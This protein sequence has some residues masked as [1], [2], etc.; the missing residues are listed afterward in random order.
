MVV[1]DKVG[2]LPELKQCQGYY[3]YDFIVHQ[4][5]H[6]YCFSDLFYKGNIPL[7]INNIH[8][9][10]SLLAYKCAEKNNMLS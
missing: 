5:R 10:I 7:I 8:T 6:S 2:N 4:Q 3:M 9:H 1:E